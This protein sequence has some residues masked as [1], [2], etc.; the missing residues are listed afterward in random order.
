MWIY[1]L[2]GSALGV[3]TDVGVV[4]PGA[5][6]TGKLGTAC[7]YSERVAVFSKPTDHIVWLDSPFSR[8]LKI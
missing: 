4:C 6:V 7:Q 8:H 2:D 3:R 1:V 5:E